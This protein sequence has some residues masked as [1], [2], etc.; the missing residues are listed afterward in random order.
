MQFEPTH[1]ASLCVGYILLYDSTPI[2]TLH[3]SW[4]GFDFR[5]S[6][7]CYCNFDATIMKNNEDP[8]I[9]RMGGEGPIA[10]SDAP[11]GNLTTA[12]AICSRK[13]ETDI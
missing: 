3:P 7:G 13:E 5:R 12:D 8:N 10:T 6:E 9:I 4:V 1:C 2:S 11:L